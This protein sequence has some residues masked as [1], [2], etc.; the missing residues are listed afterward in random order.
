MEQFP[1]MPEKIVLYGIGSSYVHEMMEVALRARVEVVAYID[2][3]QPPGNF[4]NLHPVLKPR[5][6]DAAT[7]KLPAI[8]PLVTP[9]HRKAVAIE[10]V[11]L[12]FSEK[13][14][15][16]D[17]SAVIASTTEFGDGF[18]V[19]AGVVIGAQSLFGKQVLVNRSVSIGHDAEVEDFVSFGPGCLL[20][21]SCHIETG[22][23]IGGGQPFLQALALDKTQ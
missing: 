5:Q 10:M 21:G 8:I 6:C 23:F 19:N 22:A 2:N 15:L 1:T 13:A 9:G 11:Q 20:C 16:I 4:P 14:V 18:Q 3:M 7:K 12:G 17:P